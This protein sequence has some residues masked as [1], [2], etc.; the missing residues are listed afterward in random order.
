MALRRACH[1]DHKVTAIRTNLSWGN[2]SI[3]VNNQCLAFSS[4]VAV[5]LCVT[6]SSVKAHT[7]LDDEH[8]NKE[9]H[10]ESWT[11]HKPHWPESVIYR[12]SRTSFVGRDCLESLQRNIRI[13]SGTSVFQRDFH[14]PSSALELDGPVVPSSQASL[15]CLV[16]TNMLYADL[17]EK[18]PYL[19]QC[20]TQKSG[21]F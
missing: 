10:H 5:I 18:M 11:P 20:Q 8:S 16:A 1:M 2:I 4:V 17:T 19:S 13:L 6:S 15:L 9:W 3:K 12:C 21:I 7:L 14:D